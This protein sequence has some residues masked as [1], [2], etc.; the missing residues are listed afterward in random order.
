[1]DFLGTPQ[2]ATY[3][4]KLLDQHHVPGLAISIAHNQVIDSAGF[5]KAS[6]H[7][8]RDCTPDTLF[9]IASASK[10]LTAAAV[11]V[12]IS[13]NEKHPLVQWESPMAS[14]LPKEFIMP[15]GEHDDVTVEDVLSHRTGMPA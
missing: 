6:L 7:S 14:L 12:L 8:S 9:D 5:G 2:F 4:Q 15:G 3:V 10:S 13:D 11:A 1:M